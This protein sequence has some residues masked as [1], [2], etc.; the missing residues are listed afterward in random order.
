LSAGANYTISYTGNNL[1]ISPYL[2]TVTANAQS[3]STAQADPALTF[4]NGALQTAYRAVFSAASIGSP[5]RTS[6]PM[7]STRAL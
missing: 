6:A 1:T 3:K 2:L 7:R 4:T 5:A